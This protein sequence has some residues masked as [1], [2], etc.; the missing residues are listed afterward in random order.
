MQGESTKPGTNFSFSTI[1]I[2]WARCVYLGGLWWFIKEE[3]K[4]MDA[5]NNGW[6]AV[7][8]TRPSIFDQWAL[9]SVKNIVSPLNGLVFHTDFLIGFIQF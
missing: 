5:D 2:G 8:L 1:E 9:F 4:H 3:F 7:V 6:S